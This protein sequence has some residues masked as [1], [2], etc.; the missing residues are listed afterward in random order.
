[1]RLLYR[2]TTAKQ[3]NEP[4]LNEDA[5]FAF[6]RKGIFALSDGASESYASRRWARTLVA[7]Y[8]CTPTITDRWIRDAIEAYD[9]VFD[10]AALSWSKQAAYDRGSFATLLSACIQ[11]DGI[12]LLA[13]GDSLAVIEDHGNAVHTYPYT[14]PEEFAARPFLLSTLFGR[15]QALVPEKVT[16]RWPC[17]KWDGVRIYLM[18]D[19]IGAWLLENLDERLAV[20][21]EITNALDFIDLVERER[22]NGRMRRDD[23]TLVVIG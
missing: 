7:R 22:A 18:T 17:E 11:V 5:T 6:A 1:M 8:A 16:Q 20:L 10:R 13:I 23:T 19:A 12:Q 14:K 3:Q 9:S 4:H 21:R 15:N 2:F